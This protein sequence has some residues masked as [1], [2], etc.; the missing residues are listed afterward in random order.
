MQVIVFSK[1]QVRKNIG[2]VNHAT[3]IPSGP[4]S[5]K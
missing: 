4:Q 1:T 3:Q 2:G 5:K